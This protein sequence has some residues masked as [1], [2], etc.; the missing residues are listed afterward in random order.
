MRIVIKIGT[1]TLAYETG[2]LNIRRVEELC[3]VMSDLKNAGNEI[4]LISSGAIGMGVGKLGLK[5]R[6]TDIPTKQAAAAVGQCELMYTYDK[7]FGEYNHTVAQILL[8][9]EDI[10]NK[11]RRE[12]FRN[13]IFRLLA[14]GTLPIINENDTVATNE[15]VIGDND[16][17]AAIVAANADADLLVLLSDIDGLYTSDP[18][19]NPNAELLPVV[20]QLTPEI[21][22]LAEGN[23]TALGTGGM[24]TKL[25]AAKIAMDAGIDMIIA[26]GA[27][28]MVLYNI[29]DGKSFGTRFVGKRTV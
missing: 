21:L 8:T 13:T 12:N 7:L 25:H 28:P 29:V 9:G 23:G 11:N 27:E 2:L 20:E 18:H 1:S 19:K 4:I 5:S 3:R 26:N 24:K 16:T 6:P 22:S 10:E 15:I 14:L 17:L